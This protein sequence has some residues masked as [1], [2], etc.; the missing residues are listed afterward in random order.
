MLHTRER[1]NAHAFLL[2]CEAPQLNSCLESTDHSLSLLF[3]CSLH[4]FPMRATPAM[5]KRCVPCFYFLCFLIPA[6]SPG[7]K[8][9][10]ECEKVWHNWAVRWG[11]CETPSLSISQVCFPFS[12]SLFSLLQG[13]WMLCKGEHTQDNRFRATMKTM[14]TPHRY[15]VS[16][17]FFF[18]YFSHPPTQPSIVTMKREPECKKMWDSRCNELTVS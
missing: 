15:T 5:K 8:M 12:F 18:P 14:G 1:K 2:G 17:S 9:C 10:P 4:M 3:L 6:T 11:A 13:F 16:H 7:L